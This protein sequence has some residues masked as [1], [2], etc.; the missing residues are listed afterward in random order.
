MTAGTIDHARQRVHTSEHFEGATDWGQ[1]LR[2]SVSTLADV[3]DDTP[4][5]LFSIQP[6][7][8]FEI[9][10]ALNPATARQLAEQLLIHAD[11]AETVAAIELEAQEVA[12]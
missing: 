12:P 7:G 8:N 9:R 2:L 10:A 11:I 1:P 4:T 3:G 5:V 6:F